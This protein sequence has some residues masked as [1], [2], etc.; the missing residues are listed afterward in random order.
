M[1]LNSGT[2]Y[3]GYRI[4][5]LEEITETN[6]NN[7]N[8]HWQSNPVTIDCTTGGG[9]GVGSVQAYLVCNDVIAAGGQW[10]VDGG[11]WT[12]T[13]ETI[14][15]LSAG[16]HIMSFRDIPGWIAPTSYSFNLASGEHKIVSHP[17][18]QY[19]KIFTLSLS[20]S[21]AIGGTTQGAGSIVWGCPSSTN[22]Q[23]SA[24]AS[25]GWKFDNWTE[26]GVLFADQPS[27]PISISNDRQL[28]A[29][30]SQINLFNITTIANP[31]EG[32]L[33][34]FGSWNLP[35]GSS[36]NNEAFARPNW[37]F[38][39]WTENDTVVSNAS[40]FNASVNANRIFYANFVSTTAVGDLDSAA[41]VQIAP[42]PSAGDFSIFVDTSIQIQEVEILSMI[43]QS[44]QKIL[45]SQGPYSISG[46][47]LANGTYIVKIRTTEG[48]L[49]AKKIV[50]NK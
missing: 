28:V 30:F 33:C 50:I 37:M 29:N 43:G 47:A 36:V 32:G 25:P 23:I 17:Q 1:V 46:N 40:S 12:N 31:I 42:N 19:T 44:L 22:I 49:L 2:Y 26:N 6:E 21:P 3:V 14:S 11:V 48:Y 8:Y 7:N 39:N 34:C 18:T 45:F 10:R 38:V 27:I 41:K 35:A 4:D 13:N 9:S 5:R 16:N 15:N 24:I 20:S